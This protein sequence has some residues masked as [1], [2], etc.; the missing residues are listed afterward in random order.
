M[1][2]CVRLQPLGES[3][4]INCWDRSVDIVH[5]TSLQGLESL[6][7]HPTTHYRLSCT[8]PFVCH[9]DYMPGWQ[10]EC[11]VV[12]QC[13]CTSQLETL[14]WSRLVIVKKSTH[15]PQT[16]DATALI[17]RAKTVSKAE[18]SISATQSL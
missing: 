18:S 8:K 9:G 10:V 5:Q 16:V 13:R 14:G 11:S 7:D 3:K 15:G 2:C 4:P 6:D 1:T 12:K 17:Y